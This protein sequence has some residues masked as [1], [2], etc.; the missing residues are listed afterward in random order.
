LHQI[1]F[2]HFIEFILYDLNDHASRLQTA[3]YD[4]GD[5]L[6][7]LQM[8]SRNC[9][10]DTTELNTTMSTTSPARDEVNRC[11]SGF[12]LAT[13]RDW[14]QGT[15]ERLIEA[16]AAW[17][18]ADTTAM[19]LLR[20]LQR[21]LAENARMPEPTP[22]LPQSAEWRAAFDTHARGGDAAAEP[23]GW[24]ECQWYFAESFLFR[25][26]LE[27]T[28][29]Y[30][31][32]STADGNG[33]GLCSVNVSPP[34]GAGID[35][36]AAQK[37]AEL[38]G[39]QTYTLFTAALSASSAR[40]TTTTTSTS[41]TTTTSTTTSTSTMDARLAQSATLLE[42][43]VWGNR[44][45]LCLHSL[46]AAQSGEVALDAERRNLIVN[47]AAAAC[48][49]LAAETV[50]RVDIVCDNA[51]AELLAD[52]VLSDYLLTS[53][54]DSDGDA[55]ASTVTLH[56]KAAPF[57][58]SDATSADVDE[59]IEAMST[60][61]ASSSSSSSSSDVCALQERLRA[62]VAG[63]RLVVRADAFWDGP[64]FF[65]DEALPPTLATTLAN[66]D[67]VVF[68][69][70][71]NYRRLFN[72]LP[73]HAAFHTLSFSEWL[74][75]RCQF[76]PAAAVLCLRTLKSDTVV[77]LTSGVVDKL[78]GEDNEWR[79]NGKRGVIQFADSEGVH[80]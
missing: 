6:L 27:I 26:L 56:V 4:R 63:G 17:L 13:M 20:Q 18:A 34:P 24:L 16:N 46:A 2:S 73:A 48:A 70:D 55:F 68:K 64:S 50:S 39:S 40:P 51:G 54:V 33:D 47:D 21:D 10:L 80:E 61:A 52:L 22:A 43:C 12:A 49:R 29:F 53:P 74:R 44:A 15:I 67:F 41:S 25:R 28:G 58:V 79:C 9:P 76:H 30:A 7:L 69:G 45:D 78:D 77:G 35:V 72:D 1:Y 59:H 23:C 62:H 19:T 11:D 75:G 71:C 42:F 66:S 5:F 60:L 3:M 57:L 32:V 8:S 37:R 36:F 38:H 31:A 14:H 65:T